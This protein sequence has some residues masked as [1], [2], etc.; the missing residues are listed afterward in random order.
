MTRDR[1]TAQL[2]GDLQ[3]IERQKASTPLGQGATEAALRAAL[4]GRLLHSLQAIHGQKARVEPPKPPTGLL[5][6][7]EFPAR[8][9]MDAEIETLRKNLDALRRDLA[10]DPEAGR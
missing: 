7:T 1:L 4:I 6:S 10:R 8:A 5:P 3:A 2:L 9:Q